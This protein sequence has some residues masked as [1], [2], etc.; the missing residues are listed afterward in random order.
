MDPAIAPAME[1][2][3]G[4]YAT[5][6]D[7][8]R[9]FW[10]VD[11]PA[12]APA[13]LLANS[14]GAALE[15]WD[16]QV[17]ALAGR[18]RVIRFDTRGHGRSDAPAGEYSLARL[19]A[20]AAGVLDAAGAERAHVCGLSLG[21]AVG[22]QLALDAP[23]RVERLV[24]ANT[25]ARIGNAEGW[26]AR[27]DAVA[28][29][30]L[31]GIADMALGRF[32]DEGF[33]TAHPD[34]IARFRQMLL[35]NPAHGYIGCC[36]A[37]RDA[38]LRDRVAAITSPT[39]VIGGALDVSTPPDVTDALAGSIPGARAITL[40]A[41]HLSNVEAPEAFTAALQDFLTAR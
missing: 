32:F 17:A 30:G 5:M 27:M 3:M 13:L 40:P 2:Q 26:Q 28:S 10:E 18:F 39:L 14:I 31:E 4:S 36:A 20:D 25:A 41:A 8:T 7:G 23:A 34:V 9:I 24:L 22:Q 15:M 12:G 33:R 21:G 6:T 1:G 29:G 19:A 37:L 35:A 38:D 11:G 16:A